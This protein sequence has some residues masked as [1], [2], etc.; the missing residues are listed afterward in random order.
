MLYANWTTPNPA[1][2]PAPQ[3]AI[4]SVVPPGGEPRAYDYAAVNIKPGQEAAA[5]ARVRQKH[6]DRVLWVHP[7]FLAAADADAGYLLRIER[8]ALK[9]EILCRKEA[10]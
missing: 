6:P 8:R 5:L 4:P 9:S 1:P 7:D 2:A 10:V 3:D